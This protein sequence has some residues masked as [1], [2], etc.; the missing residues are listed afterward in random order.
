[1]SKSIEFSDQDYARIQHAADA[2]GVPVDAWV[3]DRLPRDNPEADP[4]A[5]PRTMGQRLAG[6]PGRI[7]SG[8]GQPSSADADGMPVDAWVMENLPLNGH[9]KLSEKPLLDSE[10]KPARTMYDLFKGRVGVI[11]S[12]TGQP[13]S[14][15]VSQSFGEHLEE[16][17]RR[18]NL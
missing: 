7:G 6:R 15:D 17:Q 13:S 18:G 5:A 8:T 11:N 9:G 14:S 16:R 12:G 3:V 2:D 4:G 1:M 10:G